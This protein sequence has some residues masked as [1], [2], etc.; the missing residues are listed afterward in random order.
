MASQIVRDRH[1]I[2][3]HQCRYAVRAYVE[4]RSE[5]FSVAA[6]FSKH[7]NMHWDRAITLDA[8]DFRWR[9][10]RDRSVLNGHDF[11]RGQRLPNNPA[12][13][14]QPEKRRIIARVGG[15][16]EREL[17]YTIHWG[18]SQAS[19]TRMRRSSP[20]RALGVKQAPLDFRM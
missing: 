14:C 6:V 18:G 12:G 11:S 3:V 5:R 4:S 8:G 9:P 15:Q 1:V 16:E 19:P 13:K 10:R 20:V 17:G 7:D 2:G